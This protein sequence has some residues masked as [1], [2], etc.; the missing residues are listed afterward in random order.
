M[1]MLE[2]GNVCAIFSSMNVFVFNRAYNRSTNIKQRIEWVN[3]RGAFSSTYI[4][5]DTGGGA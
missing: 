4:C 2:K 5:R 3:P 1:Y